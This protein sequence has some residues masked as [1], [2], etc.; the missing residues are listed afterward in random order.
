MQ[1]QLTVHL[2]VHDTL[3]DWQPGL[4]VAHLVG[5][6][7]RHRAPGGIALQ[8]VGATRDPVRTTAGVRIVPDLTLDELEPADSAMLILAGGDAWVP[9]YDLR[10]EPEPGAE[11]PDLLMDF[12]RKARS[13]VDAGVPVAAIGGATSG[14]ARVGLLDDRV[15]TSDV[16]AFLE[17]T[18]YRGAEHFRGG[19]AVTD[20]DVITA[21]GIAPVEFAREVFA[22][23]DVFEPEV[24]DTWYRLYGEQDGSALY[25]LMAAKQPA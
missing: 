8:T 12:A 24:L 9:L 6:P 25:D 13:F 11:V 10:V 20:G 4:A 15:H 22:R 5:H 23:L 16:P 2:A 21:S 3:A 18:G 1:G 14:L 17:R 19:L 7:H